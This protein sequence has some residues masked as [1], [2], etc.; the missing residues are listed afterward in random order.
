MTERLN[1]N[2]YPLVDRDGATDPRRSADEE[3]TSPVND[4]EILA[5]IANQ[6][7]IILGIPGAGKTTLANELA[8]RNDAIDYIS[9]GDISRSLDP[10]SPE[11]IYLNSLFKKGAPLGDP[12]FFLGLIEPYINQAKDR[13]GGFLLDGLPKKPEEVQPLLDFLASNDIAID[14]VI[15]CEIDPLEAYNRTALREA[16]HGDEDSMEIYANRTKMYL[17]NISYFKD[18]LTE[19]GATLITLNTEAMGP[20]ACVDHL[21]AVNRM[22][23]ASSS[24]D[25]NLARLAG[26]IRLGEFGSAAAQLAPLFDDSFDDTGVPYESLFFDGST[27]EQKQALVEELMLQ[28]DPQLRAMPL[29]TKRLAENYLA[30]TVASLEHLV[31]SLADE[32]HAMGKQLSDK[33]VASLVHEQLATKRLIAELQAELI[34]GRDF[35]EVVD[36]EIASNADELRHISTKLYEIAHKRGYEGLNLDSDAIMRTQPLLWGQ[37][38]SSRILFAPDTNYRRNAN[39]VMGSHHSLLPFSRANRALSANS[40]AD[41]MPF[42]EAVSSS[43]YKYT[44]TF[45][46]VHLI[47]VDK[48]GEAYGVEYPIMMHDKRLLDLHNERLNHMLAS[49]DSFYSTHDIWHNIIPVYADHF[50]LHHVDAPLSY[51]GRRPSY[52]E[53]GK[54]KRQEK[55]EYEI[56]V[57]MAHAQTQQE[58]FILDPQIREQQISIVMEALDELPLLRGELLEKVSAAEADDIVDFLAARA[59]SNLFNILPPADQIYSKVDRRLREIELPALSVRLADVAT[60]LLGQRV[61]DV[62]KLSVSA[63]TNTLIKLVEEDDDFARQVLGAVDVMLPTRESGSEYIVDALQDFGILG[64]S[65]GYAETGY[66]LEGMNKVRWI[67]MMAP[68]RQQLKGHMEKVHGKNGIY[69]YGDQLLEDAREL[70]HLQQSA[71]RADM[72]HYLYRMHARK[73]NQQISYGAYSLYFDDGQSVNMLARNEVTGIMS[74]GTEAEVHEVNALLAGM[75]QLIDSLVR[76]TYDVD[77]KKIS[78]ILDQARTLSDGGYLHLGAAVSDIAH[79]YADLRND[80]IMYQQSLGTTYVAAIQRIIDDQMTIT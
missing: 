32:A 47:G 63:D 67:A 43:D 49:I 1:P 79:K 40:M 48:T 33:D 53:F 18:R 45:G 80:E 8:S 41:Y 35:A 52:L 57:A 21:I 72:P 13:G 2:T 9:V 69:K 28:K 20:G 74:N 7:T 56:G 44:S 58:R 31:R 62:S 77:D 17:E 78:D 71:L 75:D 70:V 22:E 61:I 39:G 66:I 38:T 12:D 23:L 68:Q 34:D 55:E 30:T 37:L 76:A 50:I 14:V 54:N 10:S 60:L 42:I 29:L 59:A 64:A 11:R 65:S 25:L 19:N 6:N 26:D 36:A 73:Q 15:S 4:V 5:R 16:R 46:F 51:G 24:T 3:Y 27:T